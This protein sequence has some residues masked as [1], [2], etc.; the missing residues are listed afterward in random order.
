[1][2]AG[3]LRV[4][5]DPDQLARPL[6]MYEAPSQISPVDNGYQY[7]GEFHIMTEDSEPLFHLTLPPD[8]LPSVET[9]DPPPRYGWACG[10]RFA[11]GWMGDLATF[12]FVFAARA[13]ERFTAEAKVATQ[14]I[15]QLNVYGPGDTMT[16]MEQPQTEVRRMLVAQFSMEELRTLCSDLQLNYDSFPQTLEPMARELVAY[17]ERR[18]TMP[19]LVAACQQARP[20]QGWEEMSTAVP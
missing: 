19:E 18:G 12:R 9:I 3:T 1:L 11:L 17:Q 7:L 20:G 4:Q 16:V 6:V 10:K 14:A 5:Y 15:K 13:P 8:H 2:A